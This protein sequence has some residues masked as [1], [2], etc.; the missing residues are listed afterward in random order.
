MKRKLKKF[1]QDAQSL[2]TT[3]IGLSVMGGISG[4]G[5]AAGKMAGGLGKVATIRT[6]GYV[7]DVMQNMIPKKK[8]KRQ[9]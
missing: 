3:G 8:K 5:A 2:A 1:R 4:G 6:G 9:Y 7:M